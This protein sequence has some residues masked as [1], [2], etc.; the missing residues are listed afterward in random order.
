MIYV[1]VRYRILPDS[2]CVTENRLDFD[3]VWL[4]NNY[5]LNG[6]TLASVYCRWRSEATTL[7]CDEECHATPSHT[8]SNLI[9]FYLI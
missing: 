1:Y 9:K 2:A 4:I 7:A 8:V 5:Q 6:A 3:Y